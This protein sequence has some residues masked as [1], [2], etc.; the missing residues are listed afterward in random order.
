MASKKTIEIVKST[1]PVLKEHGEAITIAFYRL[2]FEN[3]PE[4]KDIFNMTNQKKGAQQKTL[5]NTIFQYATYIEKLEMLE[6]AVDTIVQKHVSLSIPKEAYPIVGKYLL[7]GIKEVLK[8]AATAEIMDAW[9]EAYGDLAVLFVKKEETIY[10]DREANVNGFVGTK[11]F[12]IVKKEKENNYITSFYLERKDKTPV[13][14]FNAGQYICLTVQIPGTT[15]KH[16]RNYSLSDSSNQNYLRISVKKE[17]GNP[18][19]IVSNYLH[20]NLHKNDVLNI[21]MPSGNFT[22]KNNNRPLVLISGGVGITPIVSMYKEAITKESREILFIQCVLN[23]QHVAFKTEIEQLQ[24]K[25]SKTITI[26]SA[27][28]ET[29]KLGENHDYSGFLNIEIL[30]EL[31]ISKESDFYFCGP[32]PFMS[33]TATILGHLNVDP[34]FINYEFF[35]PTEELVTIS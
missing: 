22:L 35:G 25:N 8:E 23:S 15:H 19:G 10:N 26:Y 17:T 11:E 32:V 28:L 18:D 13:P 9:A 3:N 29:D 31:N 2:L 12:I 4:L 16:T 30:K 33:N 21:G 14:K 6:G 1:A 27:P 24:S 5:A 7:A 20:S 34:E